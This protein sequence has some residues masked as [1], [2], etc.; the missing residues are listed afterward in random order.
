[1]PHWAPRNCPLLSGRK[2][3]TAKILQLA[4]C[5]LYSAKV[6]PQI[7]TWEKN[8]QHLKSLRKKKTFHWF[9]ALLASIDGV[10]CDIALEKYVMT[11]EI[12]ITCSV[13]LRTIISAWSAWIFG[14]L[15]TVLTEIKYQ[16]A[17]LSMN[18]VHVDPNLIGFKSNSSFKS[19]PIP[20][21]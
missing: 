12:N 17:G 7:D 4:F 10:A 8:L 9:W 6:C 18:L 13:Q 16:T 21:P 1:M 14:S 20:S 19:L 15:K 5:G 3:W 11:H 2:Y